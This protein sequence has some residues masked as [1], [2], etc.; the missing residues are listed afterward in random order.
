MRLQHHH[1]LQLFAVVVKAQHFNESLNG[2][3]SGRKSYPW[4]PHHDQAVLG[5]GCCLGYWLYCTVESSMTVLYSSV[6]GAGW[7][8]WLYCIV[9]CSMTVFNCS[10]LGAG[11]YWAGWKHLLVERQ[12]LRNPPNSQIKEDFENIAEVPMQLYHIAFNS[13]IECYLAFR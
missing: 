4:L 13:I 3:S 7:G 5:I 8:Y 12:T 9:E 11:E 2:E 10:V 6:L 1:L